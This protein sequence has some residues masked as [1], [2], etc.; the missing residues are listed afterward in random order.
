MTTIDLW[1][2]Y[3]L[4]DRLALRSADPTTLRH[5]VVAACAHCEASKNVDFDRLMGLGIFL[6]N[7]GCT[8]LDSALVDWFVATP[9]AARLDIVCA[10]LVG[11]WLSPSAP[12]ADEVVRRLAES[13]PLERLTSDAEYS[14]AQALA[15]VLNDPRSSP[16]AV[17]IAVA[18][19]R[20]TQRRGTGDPELD[21]QLGRFAGPAV[22]KSL[23]RA[24]APLD[25]D[26]YRAYRVEE[27]DAVWFTIERVADQAEAV[28]VS[29]LGMDRDILTIR[30]RDIAPWLGESDMRTLVVR[31]LLLGLLAN[32]YEG[33][34]TTVVF[35]DEQTNLDSVDAYPVL[36][37]NP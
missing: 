25:L 32:K 8:G 2:A 29:E 15:R 28:R 21:G 14:F 16:D 3:K 19:L 9:T 4:K 10:I 31:A 12:I 30:Y 11:L 18:A 5:A 35:H 13:R 22:E 26:M 1:S 23:K 27:G 20:E 36:S 7:A 24:G 33:Q 34:A 6:A 37:G 17:H